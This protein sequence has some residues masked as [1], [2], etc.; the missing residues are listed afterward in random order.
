MLCSYF[1]W[2]QKDDE[3]LHESTFAFQHIMEK[4]TISKLEEIMIHS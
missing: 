3:W 2:K 4:K 1:L